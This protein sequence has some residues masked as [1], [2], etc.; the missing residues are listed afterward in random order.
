MGRR[1]VRVAHGDDAKVIRELREVTYQRYR[2]WLMDS[3]AAAIFGLK[4]TPWTT[5]CGRPAERD[6]KPGTG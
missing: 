1:H 6:D 3:S 2:P 5:R 4:P